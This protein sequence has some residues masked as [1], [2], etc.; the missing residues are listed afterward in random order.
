MYTSIKYVLNFLVVD[1]GSPPIPRNAIWTSKLSQNTTTYNSTVIATY[2]CNDGYLPSGNILISH[3]CNSNGS[4]SDNVTLECC[5]LII[6]VSLPVCIGYILP[7][8][9]VYTV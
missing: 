4:W 8:W 9:Y 3:T 1:C 5:E 7:K 6:T 2:K